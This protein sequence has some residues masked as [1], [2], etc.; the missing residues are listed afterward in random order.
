MYQIVHDLLQWG[1]VCRKPLERSNEGF[2]AMAIE[3]AYMVAAAHAAVKARV[4]RW[5]YRYEHVA[6]PGVRIRRDDGQ[7]LR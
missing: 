4:A 5:G 1:V 7:V 6:H 2:L 3:V